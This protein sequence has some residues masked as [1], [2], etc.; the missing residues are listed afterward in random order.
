MASEVGQAGLEPG[1]QRIMG[2]SDHEIR[3]FRR[4]EIMN[5]HAIPQNAALVR[6]GASPWAT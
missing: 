1:D 4:V 5:D 2:P 3:P 6:I